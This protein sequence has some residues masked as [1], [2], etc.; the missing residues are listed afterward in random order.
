MD[1]AGC[2]HSATNADEVR[3]ELNDPECGWAHGCAT[4]WRGTDLV[5]ALVVFDGLASGGGWMLDVY[6]LPG[7]PRTPGIN[8]ALVDAGLREGL[9]RWDALPSAPG[10]AVPVAKSGGH[11]T[12]AA[13]RA[14][15][16]QRGFAEV[17]TFLTMRIDHGGA[18]TIDRTPLPDQ[19]S[20]RPLADI[21]SEWR[22]LHEVST[23]A[24][25]DH[26][27]HA[28]LDYEEWRGHH[29]GATFDP[30]QVHV[31]EHGGHI[32]AFARGSNRY[33]S[34]GSG[35]V[36]SIGVL[37]EHRGRGLARALLGLRFAD[38]VRRG[39]H[40][41]LLHVDAASPTGADRLYSS[42]GMVTDST[43]VWFH[44]PL[45]L[46]GASAD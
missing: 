39:F 44:R 45:V 16:E 22:A 32:V 20:I 37:R 2:G 15:L 42:V 7:D 11:A 23:T 36:A 43:L 17:R 14:A 3:D 24:F 4:V 41:T 8:A 18:P 33:A 5:G 12:D 26:F 25:L 10:R 28:S 29:Q 34:E 31:V 30:T 13:L 40:S 21:P 35:Y 1:I 9:A 19:Y 46:H 27:D 6:A 38:D